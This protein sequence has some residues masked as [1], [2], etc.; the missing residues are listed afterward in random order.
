MSFQVV[1]RLFESGR[2]A[3]LTWDRV[4]LGGKPNVRS[5]SC[6]MSMAYST[7]SLS[8]SSICIVS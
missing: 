1:L 2:H 4:R 8:I 3:W 7:M 5:S 6:T